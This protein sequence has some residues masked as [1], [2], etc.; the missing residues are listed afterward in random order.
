[1]SALL[2]NFLYIIGYI[3]RLL[4][5]VISGSLFWTGG[6]ILCLI[7]FPLLYIISP[8]KEIRHRRARFFNQHTF[9]LFLWFLELWRNIKINKI[10][11]DKLK[12]QKGVLLICNHPGLLDTVLIMSHFKNIQCIVKGKLWSH[13]ILGGIVKASGYIPNNMEST[14]FLETC[15]TQLEKGENILIFPEGTRTTAGEPMKLK[16]GLSNLAIATNVDTQ[17]LIL[18]CTPPALTKSSRWYNFPQERIIFCLKA[19]QLFETKNYEPES[20]RSLRS[21]AL[22]RD[23]QAYYNRY[24]GHE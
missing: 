16:R 3:W 24:L 19:G 8:T 22:T 18:S 14:L 21:R 15:Q 20:P 4:G 7:I 13:P 11:L 2:K 6:T 23:I 10:D 17:A 5:F 1:M 12:G 9:R